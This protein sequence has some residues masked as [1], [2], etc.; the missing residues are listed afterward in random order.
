MVPVEKIE[1]SI[2]KQKC[3]KGVWRFSLD[4]QHNFHGL[5]GTSACPSRN[6][7]KGLIVLQIKG[8]PA[9]RRHGRVRLHRTQG[10]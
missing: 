8:V 4:K 3:E 6:T 9:G 7:H 10:C 1:D 2:A 5:D